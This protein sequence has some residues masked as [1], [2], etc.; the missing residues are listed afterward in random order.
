MNLE[1]IKSLLKKGLVQIFSA[2]IIN[3]VVQFVTVAALSNLITQT[4]MGEFSYAQNIVNFVLLLE[5]AGATTGIL[6]YCS[7]YKDE[8]GKAAIF[9]YGI[10]I[11]MGF[12]AILSIGL[13]AYSIFGRLPTEYEGSRGPLM[14]LAFVPILSVT[15]NAIQAYLRATLRNT[16]FSILTS[17]NTIVYFV[18]TVALSM[19]MSVNGLI[20]G[21]YL[22]Y[23]STVLL[24][25]WFIRKDIF[26]PINVS[27]IDFDKLKFLKYSIITVLT[28]AMSQ[29]LYLLDIQL[30]GV[31]T[32]DPA[33]L[34]SYKMA[35]TIPFNLMF[36]PT[37]IM[38][39]AYPYFAQNS[40]NKEWLTQRVKQLTKGLLLIN[41]IIGAFGIIFSKFI[42]GIFGREYVDAAACFNVLMIG[43]VIA[44]TFRIPYGNIIA[45]LGLVKYNLINAAF[46]GIANVILDVILIRK[47]GSIGAAYA[48][49]MVFIISSVL[50][51][52]FIKKAIKEID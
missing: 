4:E 46:S 42:M 14:L 51:Y 21:M 27:D 48:T 32:T 47:Y 38:V 11:G 30:I 50:H 9:K 31:F 41:V 12:N 8:N 1:E 44:G 15:F 52:I 18:F 43:Y 10:S 19:L 6:Q 35:T 7:M 28:N 39:F 13:F 16:Q 24:G 33:V 2:N 5:G 25:G 45:S 29:I 17:F 37:S 34:A 40:N 3:K 23:L 20:L 22:A 26:K 49:L 36:I